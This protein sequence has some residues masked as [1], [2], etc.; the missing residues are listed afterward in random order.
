MLAFESP[1]PKFMTTSHANHCESCG[2][3]FPAGVSE[4]ICPRCL[5]FAGMETQAIPADGRAQKATPYQEFIA[6]LFPELDEIKLIGRGGMGVVY[7]AHQ[8]DIRRDIALK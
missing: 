1:A 6:D 4:P 7:S 5:L 8:S 3:P 2:Q